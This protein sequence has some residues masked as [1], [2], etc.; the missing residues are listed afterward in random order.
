MRQSVPQQVRALGTF[1]ARKYEL[2][3]VGEICYEPLP[4]SNTARPRIAPIRTRPLLQVVL[5]R[6]TGGAAI[7]GL[8]WCR[9]L[10]RHLA[11][12][13]V[14]GSRPARLR[15]RLLEPTPQRV[16]WTVPG[17]SLAGRLHSLGFC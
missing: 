12:R 5:P 2:S 1:P 15:V 6:T 17:P 10:Y 16:G 4:I 13:A 11:A 9:G 8:I 14:P 3:G 7:E